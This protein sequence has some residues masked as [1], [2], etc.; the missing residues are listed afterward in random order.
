MLNCF[1][2]I[3][4]FIDTQRHHTSIH[5][6]NINQSNS[7]SRHWRLVTR[8]SRKLRCATPICNVSQQN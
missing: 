3:P 7:L 2:Y 1:Q 5:Y 8:I 4:G 6:R